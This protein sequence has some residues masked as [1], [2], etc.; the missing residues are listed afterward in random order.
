[1]TAAASR[2]FDFLPIPLL[3]AFIARVWLMALPSSLWVDELVTVFVLRFP[4]HPS[5]AAAPQVPLSIYYALPKFSW[6][7]LGDS[8]AALRLPSILAMAAALFFIARLA[9]RLID[10]RAAWLAVFACL[11]FRNFDYFAVDARPYALGIAVASAS[12]LFLIRWFDR[13]RWFDEAIFVVLAAF[14]WRIHLF[15]WPFYLVY[16]VYAAIRLARGDTRVGAG[17]IPAAV[18]T[19][20]AALLPVALTALRI[21]RHAEA[22][23]FNELPTLRNLFYL[24]HTQIVLICLAAAWVLR[25]IFKWPA[26]A[27]SPGASPDRALILCWWMA[28]P[29]ALFAYSRLAGNG[30]LIIRYASLMLPGLALTI[31]AIAARFLPSSWLKPA[32]P[33]TGLVALAFLG[34]WTTL[35][36]PHEL[37]NW[38][39][40]AAFERTVASAQTPVLWISPFIEAQPP[41]WSP[42]YPLP[43]F[44]YSSFM[45][46]PTSGQPRLFPFQPSPE[47]D[48]YAARLLRAELLPGGGFVTYG[49]TRAVRIM[50]EWFGKRPELAS[51]RRE[52]RRFDTI[53]V[54]AYSAPPGRP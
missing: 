53:S 37:D 24:L 34:Q 38:R 17:Q 1:M 20:A 11:A 3:A 36:P 12:L 5:F 54:A 40:A 13:A 46:Y 44:L 33:I 16:L 35:W 22:H 4:G 52:S 10:P 8:E 27:T 45:Y 23:A 41:V 29:V 43:G 39:D 25:R 26:L 6:A 7:M 48:R 2:R 32:A 15:Y 9:A 49:S 30:V 47:S 50:D 51:W 14:L 21:S 28:C 42:T 31:V 18:A 19:L